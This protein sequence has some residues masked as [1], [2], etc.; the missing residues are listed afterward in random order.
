MA[1]PWL[2]VDQAAPY[3]GV[4]T[5]AIY[6]AI[7]GGKFPFRVVRINRS[8][9]IWAA[10]IIAAPPVQNEETRIEAPLTK[11]TASIRAIA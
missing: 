7:S 10:D 11:E 3:L 4:S 1:E 5:H 2:S 8:I 6:R 9:R